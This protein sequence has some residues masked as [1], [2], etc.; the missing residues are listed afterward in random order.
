MPVNLKRQN[1]TAFGMPCVLTFREIVTSCGY[2]RLQFRR[3]ILLITVFSTRN[4]PAF[5][6]TFIPM[7][8]SFLT[9]PVGSPFIPS[10]NSVTASKKPAIASRRSF[11]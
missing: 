6:L 3:I 5:F 10:Y 2:D 4:Y 7:R 1:P 11:V 9:V 8:S